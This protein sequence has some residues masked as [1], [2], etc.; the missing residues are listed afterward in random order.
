ME[1]MITMEDFK[2]LSQSIDEAQKDDTPYMGV[3]NDELHVMGDP[4]KT[5]LIPHTYKVKFAFPKTD[6]WRKMVNDSPM[7]RFE[8]E[9]ENF[10]VAYREYNDIW[11]TPRKAGKCIEAFTRL[12]SFLNMINEEGEVERL[13]EEQMQSVLRYMNKDVEDSVYEAV[14][15]VIG[16]S[17]V[18]SE[19]ITIDSAMFNAMKIVADHPDIIN[20]SDLFFG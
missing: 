15:K 16:I 20:S 11:V 12:I 6:E 13:T 2:K 4:N 8:K 14:A 18:E 7:F 17:E 9:T 1:T 3:I 19:Y 5:E 10:I